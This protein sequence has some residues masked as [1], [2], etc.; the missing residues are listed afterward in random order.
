MPPRATSCIL[1]LAFPPPLPRVSH[2]YLCLYLCLYL[3]LLQ[4]GVG[5]DITEKKYAEMAEI[6]SHARIIP[7]VNRRN[8]VPLS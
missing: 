5:Q 7:L 6:T 4:V 3:Y 8:A 1:Q 2:L